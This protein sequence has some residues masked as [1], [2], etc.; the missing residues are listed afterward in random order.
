[1]AEGFGV[2]GANT[3]LDAVMSAYPWLK[4]HIGAPGVAGTSN[5]AVETTR[6]QVS[7]SPASAGAGT[8]SAQV[9][10]TNVAGSEDYTYGSF[11]SA[12]SGGN[13]GFSGAVTANAVAAGDT[14]T[15]AAGNVDLTLSLAS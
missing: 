15:I 7:W 5:P 6:K 10:W 1:V 2:A 8:S 3:A 4:L 9:Q 12:S 14:F 13:F 11:W